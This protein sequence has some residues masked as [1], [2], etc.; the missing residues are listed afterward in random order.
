VCVYVSI[1]QRDHTFKAVERL[2]LKA[3]PAGPWAWKEVEAAGEWCHLTAGWALA[4]G[5]RR[6][7]VTQRAGPDDTAG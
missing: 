4:P 1:S 5:S 2:L 3:Q 6:Q 7:E